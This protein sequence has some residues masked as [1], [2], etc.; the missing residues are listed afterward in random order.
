MNTTRVERDSIGEKII[1]WDADYGIHTA[2]AAENF[3]ITGILLRH[4]P[5]LVQSL[6]MV[7]KAAAQANRDLGVLKPNIAAAIISACDLLIAGD[8]LN[9]FI[10]DMLQGGAG[11]SSNM[12]VNEVVA[13]VALKLLG[14][15]RGD[16]TVINPNDHVNLSQST[17]DVY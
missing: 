3:P 7:K 17:N 11:T 2:R 12:N 14:R 15:P 4:Y 5:E 10:V 8:G 13:N 16:Y 9:H 6:V 1:P